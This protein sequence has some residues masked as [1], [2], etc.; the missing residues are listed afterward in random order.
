MRLKDFADIRLSDDGKAVITSIEPMP[1]T[2]IVHWNCAGTDSILYSGEEKTLKMESGI[3]EE[4]TYPEGTMVQLER[5][6]Y[7]VI[8]SEALVLCHY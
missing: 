1:G 4:N 8:E 2:N 7:A 6:G 5:I 3:L